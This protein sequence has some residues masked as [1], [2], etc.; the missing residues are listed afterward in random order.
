[1]GQLKVSRQI[2]YSY[3]FTFTFILIK[4]NKTI[5][6]QRI[7]YESGLPYFKLTH[8]THYLESMLFLLVTVAD[9]ILTLIPSNRD[10]ALRGLKALSVLRDL[11]AL[12]SEQPRALATRLTR[13]TWEKNVSRDEQRK[14]SRDRDSKQM[15]MNT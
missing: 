12:S 10:R 9:P 5:S 13:E 14:D 3:F 15:N 11:I 1:M 4:I 8:E 2:S 7:L 6:N